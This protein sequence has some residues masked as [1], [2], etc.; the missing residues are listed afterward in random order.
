MLA[1]WPA[2]A[3]L[4]LEVL[5]CPHADVGIQRASHENL[6]VRQDARRGDSSGMPRESVEEF[7]VL[8]RELFYGRR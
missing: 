5:R 2:G 1:T 6:R 4:Y 7:Q 3:G 8:R